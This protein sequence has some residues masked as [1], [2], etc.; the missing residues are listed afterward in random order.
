MIESGCKVDPGSRVQRVLNRSDCKVE[1][2]TVILDEVKGEI[3][4]VVE[5]HDV[6]RGT[7]ILKNPHRYEIYRRNTRDKL[8]VEID[9]RIVVTKEMMS[10]MVK[11]GKEIEKSTFDVIQH[12]FTRWCQKDTWQK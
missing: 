5:G 7:A 6:E 4:H 2:D 3:S 1:K 10:A 9:V 12:G 8:R 11:L